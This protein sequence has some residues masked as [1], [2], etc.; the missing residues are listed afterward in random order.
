M[1]RNAQGWLGLGVATVAIVAALVAALGTRTS[2]PV[3]STELAVTATTAAPRAAVSEPD[4]FQNFE[5]QVYLH[6]VAIEQEAERA[7]LAEIARQK[8]AEAARRAKAA[9]D[10]ARASRSSQQRSTPAQASAGGGILDALARCESGGD[11]NKNTGNGYYGAFQF[12]PATWRSLGY[13]GLPTDHSYET[14]REAAGR[15]IARSG[16]GQFPG[17]ARKLGMR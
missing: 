8:A 9:Q 14:Q 12:L 7:R 15:L 1:R 16:W 5:G 10:A 17:C 6:S 13:S 3:E 11:P 2:E 4:S